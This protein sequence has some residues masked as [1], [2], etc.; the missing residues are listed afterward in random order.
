M[1]ETGLTLLADRAYLG[2][3]S[4]GRVYD[5]SSSLQNEI[6]CPYFIDG[7][8]T[9]KERIANILTKYGSKFFLVQNGKQINDLEE[10][11][12]VLLP[13]ARRNG[14][15]QSPLVRFCGMDNS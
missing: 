11:L 8:L 2:A 1:K 14:N 6:K 15:S 13:S 4:D 12:K 5:P 9:T 10:K 7:T 3:S